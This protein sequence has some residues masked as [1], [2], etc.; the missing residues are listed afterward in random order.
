MPT[1]EYICTSCEKEWEQ[2]QSITEPTTQECLH[3]QAPTAKRV[4]SKGTGFQLLGKGWA[5][6]N[7]SKD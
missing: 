4:I 7:Y 6:D 5:V 3:C 1:Y 2:F